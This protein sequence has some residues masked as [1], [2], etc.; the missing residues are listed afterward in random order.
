M[1]GRECTCASRR[2]LRGCRRRPLRTGLLN[3]CNQNTILRGKVSE[4]KEQARVCPCLWAL[5]N[6]PVRRSAAAFAQQRET[7]HHGQVEKVGRGKGEVGRRFVKSSLRVMRNPRLQRYGAL[8]RRV[9]CANVPAAASGVVLLSAGSKRCNQG[10]KE[11][12]HATSRAN[13]GN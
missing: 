1:E 2:R 8:G 10:L 11:G 4:R 6:V 3:P 12:A 9:A 7:A 5:L 13:R